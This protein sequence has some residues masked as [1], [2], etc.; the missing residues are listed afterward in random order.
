MTRDLASKESLAKLTADLGTIRQWV[1]ARGF[2]SMNRPARVQIVNSDLVLPHL[3]QARKFLSEMQAEVTKS[4]DINLRVV[5]LAYELS[6]VQPNGR[7]ASYW[8]YDDVIEAF[9]KEI[10]QVYRTHEC[11]LRSIDSLTSVLLQVLMAVGPKAT[12]QQI[13]ALQGSIVELVPWAKARTR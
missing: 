5:D 6:T 1:T 9:D 13:S 8:N 7:A 3:R 2:G 10:S 12:P 11:S 4:D